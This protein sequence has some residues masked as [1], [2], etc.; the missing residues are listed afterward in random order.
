MGLGLGFV[1]GVGLGVQGRVVAVVVDHVVRAE[2]CARP[3]PR[4]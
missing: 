1:L 4:G 3:L 2:V